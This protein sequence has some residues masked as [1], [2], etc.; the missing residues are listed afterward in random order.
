MATVK[1]SDIIDVEI[2][3]AIAP[4]N[5]PRRDTFLQSG[6][7]I[8]TPRMNEI[9]VAEAELVNLPFWRDLDI[10]IEPNYS[11]DADTRSTPNKIVQGRMKGKRVSLNQSWATRDLTNEMTMG[12]D[13]MTRIRER[14]NYY[15]D[16]QLQ[17]RLIATLRGI[18]AANI[19]ASN[20]G[21]DT[22]F[23]VTG[24]M[25][26]DISIDNGVGTAPNFFSF[27]AFS[28][29]RFTLGDN[30]DNL[31]AVLCHSVIRKRMQEQDAIDYYRDSENGKT[32]E[33]YQGH[34]LIV[35]DE[36]PTFATTTGGGIRYITTL[37]GPA[38]FGYGEGSPSV[39]VEVWRDPSIGDGGGEEVLYER[40]TWIV[41]P[42]GH[43]NENATNSVAG[44]LWQNLADCRLAT[45]WKRNVFRKNAPIAFLV[46]NG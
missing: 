39:P 35:S 6:V 37:F 32:I 21:I 29:A 8:Q 4:E 7:M 23:G 26:Y 42:F 33:L 40:K 44:G 14:T 41:H 18:Y 46:T 20:A 16:M 17:S 24:D 11:S 10:G 3:N 31:S 28:G 22:G 13:A 5:N 19:R 36:A 1:L 30:V 9:A 12:D 45:N 34:R 25:V 38:A 43:S 15:W 27:D 2:Y